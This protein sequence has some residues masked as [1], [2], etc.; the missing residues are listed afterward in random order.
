MQTIHLE[1][2]CEYQVRQNWAFNYLF[3]RL[4]DFIALTQMAD[5]SLE[6][7]LALSIISV[8]RM[9][10]TLILLQ[11]SDERRNQ[12]TMWDNTFFQM[13]RLDNGMN[14]RC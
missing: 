2:I 14:F 13:M 8:V 7:K 12:S 9:L 3:G 5:D 1:Q 11:T 4:A 6:R 10:G